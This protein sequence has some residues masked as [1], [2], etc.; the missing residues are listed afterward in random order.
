MA[1]HLP[2][3]VERR[4]H[5]RLGRDV[6]K[7]HISEPW[8]VKPS[9][10]RRV[11]PPTDR[12][13]YAE[14]SETRALFA[15]GS[16]ASVLSPASHV[17]AVG[18]AASL[19]TPEALGFRI[20]THCTRGRLMDRSAQALAV[21]LAGAPVRTALKQT[22]GDSPLGSQFR[23]FREEVS[24][25]D[26]QSSRLLSHT[27]QALHGLAGKHNTCSRCCCKCANQ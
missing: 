23:K 18:T 9:S 2:V 20:S 5:T 17:R 8:P 6:S 25:V 11:Y 16:V 3:L 19:S 13:R 10:N 7:G 24:G 12:G 26:A 14:G 27:Q 15:S 1:D 22:L 4:V 21:A